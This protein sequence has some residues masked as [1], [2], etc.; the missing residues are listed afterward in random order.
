MP[1]KKSKRAMT[2]LIKVLK[3]NAALKHAA[4]KSYARPESAPEPARMGSSAAEMSANT[5]TQQAPEQE[6]NQETSVE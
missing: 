6:Q 3:R 1:K 2:R 4:R 5:P